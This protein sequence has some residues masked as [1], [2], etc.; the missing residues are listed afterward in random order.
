M[1]SR[2]STFARS[3]AS[4]TSTSTSS[5]TSSPRS[6]IRASRSAAPSARERCRVGDCRNHLRRRRLREPV[7]SDQPGPLGDDG[8]HGLRQPRPRRVRDGGRV[9]VRRAVAP[10]GHSVPGYV[11]GGV[12]GDGSGRRGRRGAPLPAALPSEP[13]RPGALHHWP[14]LHG[15]RGRHLGL[16]SFAAAGDAARLAS[17]TD[18]DRWC[19]RERLPAVSHHLR[20][21][22]LGSARHVGG[23]HPLRSAAPRRG[24]QP[25][26][27]PPGWV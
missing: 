10:L 18:H 8:P 5:S 19:G 24:R 7:V 17:Q 2:T 16:G 25:D 15:E 3:S 4:V 1:W 20:A 14:H 12:R 6:R 11:A 27:P 23:A 22:S 13:P 9:H 21:A 26:R